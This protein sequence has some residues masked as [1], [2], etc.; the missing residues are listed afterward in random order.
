MHYKHGVLVLSHDI[1]LICTCG[2][3][4]WLL[5][6]TKFHLEGGLGMKLFIMTIY[7]LIHLKGDIARMHDDHKNPIFYLIFSCILAYYA[8]K[9]N[10]AH[11]CSNG[12]IA[13]ERIFS[14]NH[15]WGICNKH[16]TVCPQMSLSLTI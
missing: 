3:W 8:I 16:D 5:K 10:D 15:I 9:A 12:L 13:N 6:L 2:D 1:R 14:C 11:C 7:E 4:A